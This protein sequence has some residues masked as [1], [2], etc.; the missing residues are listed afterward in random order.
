MVVHYIKLFNSSALSR[1]LHLEPLHSSINFKDLLRS[2][3]GE[4]GRA[5][6][7]VHKFD[8]QIARCNNSH[9]KIIGGSRIFFRGAQ[10]V[11]L[12]VY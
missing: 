12:D 1:L 5:S 9:I 8:K 10:E 3:N 4:S 7:L 2:L 11:H 6:H